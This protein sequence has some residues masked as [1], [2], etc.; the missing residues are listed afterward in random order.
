MPK[1]YNEYKIVSSTVASIYNQPTFTSELI[2]QALLWEE[3]LI[4]RKKNNWYKVKQRD[5]Y[6]GWIHSFY[7][8]DSSIY[9]NNKQ[10]QNRNNWYWVKDKSVELLLKD[11]T[12]LEISFGSLRNW[13]S[14]SKLPS[15]GW[16]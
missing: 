1:S 3:L 11:N 4:C 8:V 15:K 2:T 5:G 14:S 13:R 12:I 6:I 16:R 7:I 10:L 9:K